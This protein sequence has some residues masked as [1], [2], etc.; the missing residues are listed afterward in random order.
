MTKPT[1]PC[2]RIS[3][4]AA[5]EL[6][7]RRAAVAKRQRKFRNGISEAIMTRY[8]MKPGKL[9]TKLAAGAYEAREASRK[10]DDNQNGD[11]A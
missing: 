6:A 3:L 7:A 10:I 8:G 2:R 1:P 9:L 11:L 4:S 5:A